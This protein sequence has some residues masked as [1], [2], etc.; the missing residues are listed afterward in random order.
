MLLCT[1]SL[2]S[3]LLRSWRTAGVGNAI[4]SL[5]SI[6]FYY[7]YFWHE[8]T[9]GTTCSIYLRVGSKVFCG[10]IILFSVN[11]G[12]IFLHMYEKAFRRLY[13]VE[14]KL[15][16]VRILSLSRPLV[17]Q[18]RLAKP[19]GLAARRRA[20]GQPVRSPQ[21]CEQGTIVDLGHQPAAGLFA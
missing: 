12:T 7:A 13:I 6:V 5:Y 3:F 1:Q 16:A 4:V 8:T 9:A 18:G 20:H 21:T 14:K 11:T 10:L 15:G 2:T 19:A 17:E